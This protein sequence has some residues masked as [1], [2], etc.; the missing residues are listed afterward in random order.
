MSRRRMAGKIRL[1]ISFFFCSA[2]GCEGIESDLGVSAA[3]VA[4]AATSPSLSFVRFD[5]AIGGSGDGVAK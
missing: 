3:D 5:P 2:T 1:K 4:L